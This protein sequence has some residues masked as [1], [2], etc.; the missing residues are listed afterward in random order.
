MKKLVFMAMGLFALS[1][2]SCN[3]K[4]SENN[5]TVIVDTDSIATDTICDVDSVVF[6]V[7]SVEVAE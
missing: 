7:D 2:V 5:E 1:M 6:S 3:T 4:Q